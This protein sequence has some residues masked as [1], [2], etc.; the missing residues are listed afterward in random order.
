MKFNQSLLILF[1]VLMTSAAVSAQDVS[2]NQL[3]QM[4]ENS[5]QNLTTY[6]YSRYADTNL[7]YANATI[8]KDFSA[9]KITSG[10]VDLV[11]Q[12]GS[13]DSNLADKTSGQVLTW[14]GYLVNGTEY[15][16]EGQ[17]WTAF[18][19]MNK[20]RLLEDYNEIPGQVNLVRYSNMKIVGS[21]MVQGVDTYK[22]VG[23]P[24][25][26]IYRGMI[27]LQLLVAY[28]PSP[29]TVPDDIKKGSIVLGRTGLMNNSNITLTA[30]VTK[31]KAM[32]KRLDINS[33]LTISPKILNTSA[34]NY[35]IVSKIN[36]STVYSGFGAPVKI[37]LPNVPQNQSSSARAVDYRWA[38]F[39][40]VR[41]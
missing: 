17:N 10:K 14:D 2:I 37:E 6:S 38:L 32:L 21:E 19:R 41:P 35:T 12:T 24:I 4:M 30:W 28:V 33:S 22:L 11:N 16:K 9:V 8:Y 7:L 29:F 31:D 40:S 25:G 36:E 13:W 3:T 23:T 18:T 27:G 1:A 26:P 5:T 39:G 20:S 34:P 15:W